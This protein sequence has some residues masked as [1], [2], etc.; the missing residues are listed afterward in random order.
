[1]REA[2]NL[3]ESNN[4]SMR[5]FFLPV[6]QEGEVHI[7]QDVLNNLQ[8]NV[9]QSLT[10]IQIAGFAVLLPNLPKVSELTNNFVSLM[11]DH[12]V[13][14]DDLLTDLEQERQAIWQERQMQVKVSA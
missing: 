2:M 8:T 6:Q 3:T 14:L 12:H 4:A 1:M 9:G 10:L 13:Y 7:P 11:N 5:V